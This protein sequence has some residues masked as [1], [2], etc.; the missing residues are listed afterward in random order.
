MYTAVDMFAANPA[1]GVG[2]NNYF[3]HIETY[4]PPALKGTWRYTVHNEYL[5]WLSETGVIGFVLYYGLFILAVKG[6]WGGTR[7]AD[8]WVF[9]I[10]AGFFSALI[11]SIPNRFFTF[12]HFT[13]TYLLYCIV[14]AFAASFE[15]LERAGEVPEEGRAG[16]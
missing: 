2:V 10:A 3:V 8:P 12:Y 5:L 7:F 9:I 15:R 16:S 4:L 14:L 13:P 1:V 6:L 11:G